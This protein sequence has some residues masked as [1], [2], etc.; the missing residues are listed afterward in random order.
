LIPRA[1]GAIQLANLPGSITGTIRLARWAA[2]LSVGSH[3]SRLA[4]DSASVRGSRHKARSRPEGPSSPPSSPREWPP[5]KAHSVPMVLNRR[6]LCQACG[7]WLRAAPAG[8][9]TGRYPPRSGAGAVAQDGRR[10]T[11]SEEV[12]GPSRGHPPRPTGPRPWVLTVRPGGAVRDGG[13]R[14]GR[15]WWVGAPRRGHPGPLRRRPD[16][17]ASPLRPCLRP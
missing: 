6:G 14:D 12:S 8:G 7:A 10:G 4:I 2:S 15:A 5:D 3:S 13:R 17:P 16:V 11:R 9:A 1:G